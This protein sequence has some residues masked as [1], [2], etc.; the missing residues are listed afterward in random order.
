MMKDAARSVSLDPDAVVF[1]QSRP[2]PPTLP[3]AS[4]KQ[5]AIW[6]AAILALALGKGAG[7]DAHQH[8]AGAFEVK[9]TPVEGGD[10]GV[11]AGHLRGDKT[12]AGD[13]TGTSRGDMWTAMT[14]VEGS[15]GYVAIEKIEGTLRGRK[16]TF[17]VLHQGTMRRG[18]EYQIRIVIVPESGTGQLKG[19]SGTMSIRI[20]KDGG[21]FYDLDYT[22]PEGR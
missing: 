17:T 8:A 20:E 1:V 14:E 4:M 12:F 7:V 9:M 16:G 2:R 5:N 3:S 19:L 10:N 18:A 15:A 6:S 13:L 21:H 11:A 22:L